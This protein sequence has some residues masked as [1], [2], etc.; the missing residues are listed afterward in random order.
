MLG[1]EIKTL[2]NEFSE[3]GIQELTLNGSDLASGV[4]MIRM[5]TESIQKSHKISLIK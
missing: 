5:V 3:A 2:F 1:R 4:Y